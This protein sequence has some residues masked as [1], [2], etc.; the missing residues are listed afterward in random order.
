MDFTSK[1][2]PDIAYHILTR[3]GDAMFYK[4]LIMQVIEKKNKPVQSLPA[5]ISE[6]YTFIN[7]DSRFCHVGNG[8]WKLREWIPQDAKAA[9]STSAPKTAGKAKA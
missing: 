8:M 7:M 3:M 9:A 6:V 4:D 1:T 5:A 2:E